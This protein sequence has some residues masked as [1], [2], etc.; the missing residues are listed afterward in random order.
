MRVGSQGAYK[1]CRLCSLLK[2]F[3]LF[4]SSVETDML[5]QTPATSRR[6]TLIQV[7]LQTPATCDQADAHMR[8]RVVLC[9]RAT[10][11]M[12]NIAS[13]RRY[14][15]P[16]GFAN[17]HAELSVSCRRHYAES[18]NSGGSSFGRTLSSAVA[19]AFLSMTSGRAGG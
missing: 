17:E 9:W 13:P 2:N 4:R 18:P 16:S 10:V 7:Q 3:S 6:V 15:R 11:K 19:A 14:E 8:L 5:K 12:D 1:T